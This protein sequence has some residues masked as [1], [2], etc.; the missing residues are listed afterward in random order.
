MVP[1]IGTKYSLPPLR[2]KLVSRAPTLQKLDLANTLPLSLV[3]A[4]AGFGKSTLVRAWCAG[5]EPQCAWLT[6]DDEDNDPARFWAYLAAALERVHPDLSPLIDSVQATPNPAPQTIVAALINA[7]QNRDDTWLV[8]DDYHLIE[9]QSLHT[10]LEFWIDHLPAN[11]HLIVTT[12]VDPPW[13]LSRWRA[14]HQLNE[15]RVSDLRWTTDEAARFLR[16]AM[17]VPLTDAQIET[18]Q[19]RT[20]GWIAGLQLSALALTRRTNVSEFIETFS[21]SQRYIISYLAEE[22]LERLPAPLLTFLLKTCILER[23]NADLSHAVTG[24]DDAHARLAQLYERN[25]FLLPLDEHEEWYRYHFLFAEVLRARQRQTYDAETISTLHEAASEWFEEN[26]LPGEAIQHA[27]DARAWERAA[28][29]IETHA[30]NFWRRG[31]MATLERRLNAIPRPVIENDARLLLAQAMTLILTNPSQFARIDELV[32]RA[33]QLVAPNQAGTKELRARLSAIAGANSSNQG[34]ATRTI[35]LTRRALSELAPTSLFWR[36]LTQVNLGIAYM[37]HGSPRDAIDALET[38]IELARKGEMVYLGF[39]G[40]M[41]LAYARMLHGQL[42]AAREVFSN[43]LADL[44]AHHLDASPVAAYVYGGYGKLLYEWNDLA[45]SRAMLERARERLDAQARGWVLA[46]IEMD[47]ARVALAEHNTEEADGFLAHVGEVL[48]NEAIAWMRP[49]FA[50]TLAR[51]NLRTGHVARAAE[52]MRQAAPPPREP[53]SFVRE[54]VNLTLVRVTLAQGQTNEAL[55]LLERIQDAA[56]SQERNGTVL[57]TEML[58]ALC[59]SRAGHA[60]RAFVHLERALQMG[61]AENF[62]RV[63]VDEGEPMLKLLGDWRLVRSESK[64]PEIRDLELRNYADALLTVLGGK[65]PARTTQS[66]IETLPRTAFRDP[67]PGAKPG[68][69][70]NALLE[71]LSERELQVLRLIAAGASNQDI[72]DKLV[73]ALPTVKRHISNIYAKLG[74]TSRTQALVRA[75]ELKLL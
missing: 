29:L 21:G 1:L 30:E 27:L 6:L 63:F 40:R 73:I 46:E 22:V 55:D 60:A 31:E 3:I 42:R 41:H 33:G 75:Q 50:A 52:W 57:E 38:G 32:Q 24:M 68:E 65:I 70:S 17:D 44:D 11:V 69:D 18:L 20:E 47:C 49:I 23:F 26:A 7:L 67:I 5:R 56:R 9:N 13:H 43:V 34:D 4:A 12:R 71:S 39:F 48:D 51:T 25:L 74:V 45:R 59:L 8:L 16:Q 35:E 2:T 61:H 36:V 64:G 14:R 53:V 19:T 15:L 66:K 58:R 10:A 62:V 28:R 54:F 72:A 37:T